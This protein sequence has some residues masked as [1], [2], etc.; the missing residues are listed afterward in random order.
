MKT[1]QRYSNTNPRYL[2][3]RTTPRVRQK[4][5]LPIKKEA[6]AKHSV[7]PK[8]AI[9]LGA[10]ATIMIAILGISILP[11]HLFASSDK[12]SDGSMKG[13]IAIHGMQGNDAILK[14]L[15]ESTDS[16]LLTLVNRQNAIPENRD[17]NLVEIED[18]KKVDSR[19]KDDLEEML[20]AC[21]DTGCH[22]M[23]SS[24]FRSNAEQREL[25]D[26]EVEQFKQLGFSD[27]Y[28]EKRA[29]KSVAIPGT[30]EHELGLAI[31][32]VDVLNQ[33][34]D[35]DQVSSDTQQWMMANSWKYGFILRYPSGKEDI[36]G[37]VFEP[38]H[39]RYL[40]RAIAREVHESGLSYEEFLEW[41]TR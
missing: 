5:E 40:T 30:S 37:I 17:I 8:A 34:L 28:A 2:R 27:K 39:Y 35:S 10:V 13:G 11:N 3:A 23:I 7:K 32:I 26:A 22:P 9:I 18:G 31:D 29:A 14:D 38:W 15:I 41:A 21:R 4:M 1:I 25:F 19:C 16:E 20:K 12:S 24:A 33:R 6:R 36:T